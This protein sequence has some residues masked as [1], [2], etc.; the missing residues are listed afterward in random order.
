V[1]APAAH[2]DWQLL[3]E[4]CVQKCAHFNAVYVLRE[5]ET[6]Q[7]VALRMHAAPGVIITTMR[8]TAGKGRLGRVW[9][10]TQGDG[11][12]VTFVT[13]RAAP[14]RLALMSAVAA[15]RA[16]A[17]LLKDDDEPPRVRIRWPNDVFVD[18]RKLAGILVE[19]DDRI[20]RIGVGMNITQRS[21]PEEIAD[22]AC[23][24][25]Q[26]GVTVDRAAAIVT[27]IECFDA[28]LAESDASLAQ[29]FAGRDELCGRVATFEHRGET[30]AGRILDIDPA[31][32][33]R[34][35]TDAGEVF[36]PAQTTSLIRVD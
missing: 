5:T 36:L 33:L 8:Q 30:F 16:A 21:F 2:E 25:A 12:A 27:L 1:T 35:A 28:A 6:T 24:L 31:R 15:C 26:L 7:D 22:K 17:A 32:G 9:A 3:L 34:I 11:I 10:D 4:S 20:A 18:G 29:A 23:S 14:E 13:R 19:Q